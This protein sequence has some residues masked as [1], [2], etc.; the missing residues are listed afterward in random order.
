YSYGERRG[1]LG[2]GPVGWGAAL[3]D[4]ALRRPNDYYLVRLLVY[5]DPREPHVVD[6]A[7]LLA[8]TLFAR[9]AA[10]YA[11]AVEDGPQRAADGAL[12][13]PHFDALGLE[14]PAVLAILPDSGA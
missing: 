12:L 10:G 9:V 4:G 14:S 11:E 6:E 3:L 8:D 2:N 7:G 1:R 5:R 13:A